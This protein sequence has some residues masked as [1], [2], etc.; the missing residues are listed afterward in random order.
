[1]ENTKRKKLKEEKS[2]RYIRFDWA[3][4]RLLRD[5]ANYVVLEGFLSVLLGESVYIKTFLKSEGNQQ[6]ENDKYNRVDILCE[7]SHSD[8]IIIEVQNERA[9]TYFHRML[10]GTSK[11]ITEYIGLGQDYD[12]I[13]KVYSINIVYF[14]LGQGTDYVYHGK[15]EFRGLHT[16]DIL[17]LSKRQM[18]MFRGKEAGDIFP[19]YYVLKVN[20]FDKTARTPLDEWISFLKTGEI[21]DHY[22]AQGLPEARKKLRIDSLSD[23][24]RRR[25]YW[26]MENRM[27]ENDVM[28]SAYIDGVADGREQAREEGREEGILSVARNL[29]ASGIPVDVI[30]R[31]TGL[32]VEEIDN[33]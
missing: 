13:R 22:T 15:T 1:M 29:K 8:L 9:Y 19:E 31:N 32:T 7:D 6:E 4:K 3:M 28:R 11:V 27:A 25:Y 2:M 23:A 24:E 33:L 12:H 26:E 18:E 5:K 16:K 10:Y 14:Q 17:H 20:D 30:A 21:D